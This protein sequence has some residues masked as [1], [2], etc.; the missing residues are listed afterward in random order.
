MIL[1][2]MYRPSALCQVTCPISERPF[3]TLSWCGKPVKI[4]AG[5]ETNVT[6]VRPAGPR[7]A[8]PVA[9]GAARGDGR[10]GAAGDRRGR[11]SPRQS[12]SGEPAGGAASGKRREDGD[13]SR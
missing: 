3:P 12:P 7:R 9:D 5:Q 13:I 2:V 11:A 1:R 4:Q 10:D 8:G 6:D